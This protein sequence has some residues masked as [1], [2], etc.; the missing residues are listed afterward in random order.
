MAE[1]IKVM[2]CA[3]PHREKH[4]AEI[5]LESTESPPEGYD[6]NSIE[7]GEVT[8]D[9]GDFEFEIFAV[10]ENERRTFNAEKLVVALKEG[11][12]R[13]VEIYPELKK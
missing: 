7:I 11:M 10:Q 13:L 9:N 6:L 12:A 8:I 2:I 1:E 3:P 5:Y 4:V